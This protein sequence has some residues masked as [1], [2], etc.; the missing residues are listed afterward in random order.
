MAG[1]RWAFRHVLAAFGLGVVIS[2]VTVAQAASLGSSTAAPVGVTATVVASC[3]SDGIGVSWD[4]G[5]TSPVF[6]GNATVTS[7][8]YNVV[9]VKLTEVNAA[10][11]GQNYKYTLADATGAALVSGSG[12]AVVSGGVI[13]WSFSAQNSKLISQIIV[14]LYE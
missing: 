13:T 10:C 2:G 8:T 5:A 1:H 3:D 7:S 14:A 4:N 11:N 12:T 9:T 6:S